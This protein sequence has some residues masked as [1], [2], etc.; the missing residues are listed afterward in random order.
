MTKDGNF[1]STWK[2]KMN[3]LAIDSSSSTLS[4]ALE[5]ENQIFHE[6]INKPNGHSEYLMECA[7][8]LCKSAGIR[9][10]DLGMVAC[11]K[12]P[13]SFTGLR[14]GFSTA[15][16][17][18]LALGI[19]LIAVPTL[20]CLAYPFSTQPGLV[21]PVLDAKKNCFFSA[22]YRGG[23][24]LTDFLDA[25]AG[26]LLKIMSSIMVSA[27]EPILLTG[28]GAKLFLSR[29][30]GTAQGDSIYGDSTYVKEITKKMNLDKEFANGRATEL[31]KMTKN[32]NIYKKSDIDGAPVYLRK[33]DAE[34]N[35]K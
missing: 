16:G 17:I 23:E 8:S 14:I 19:P 28:A 4:V 25:R 27:N 9:P 1:M 6:E 10:S 11:M 32:S 13:G 18:A 5:T 35:C 30:E 21:L 22:F 7:D 31:L 34:L 15:K 26:E 33:S 24:R 3:I 12:G 2:T 29:F 20:D